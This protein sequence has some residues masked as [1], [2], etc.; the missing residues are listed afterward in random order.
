M[1]KTQKKRLVTDT[2]I[3]A[4]AKISDKGFYLLRDVVML[5]LN[6]EL[7][8]DVK[9]KDILLIIGKKYGIT[10]A[11]A[12]KYI[13]I[14]IE[15]AMRYKDVDFLESYFGIDYRPETGSVTP[16]S[17]ILRIVD[18][19]KLQCEEIEERGVAV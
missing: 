1:N 15:N 19:A 4:G 14:P 8:I 5:Y 12:Q 13:R 10:Y 2:L 11:M 18:D 7:P 9:Q 3:K 16:Q 17:F 6:S